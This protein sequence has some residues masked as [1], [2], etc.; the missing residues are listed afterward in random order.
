M[1]E[2]A[3]DEIETTAEPI[4]VPP[5]AL[6]PA[7]SSA[8]APALISAPGLPIQKVPIKRRPTRVKAPKDSKVYKVAIATIALKAQGLKYA[9]ISEQL[10]VPVETIKTYIKRAN[11]KGWLNLNSFDDPEDR[12]E[13][14]LKHKVVKNLNELIDERVADPTDPMKERSILSSR[15]MDVSLEV[16]KGTGLLKQHQV[17]K[18]DG[19]PAVGFA[20]KVQVEFPPAA[21]MSAAPIRAGHIGGTPAIN[22]EVIDA[23][24]E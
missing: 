4:S 2:S 12:I 20:L 13:H 19:P 16:A 18:N 22:A 6:L 3:R 21:A 10:G 11:N 14:V 17:V 8:V 15:A 24:E 1:S 5:G 9:E 23:G 7:G